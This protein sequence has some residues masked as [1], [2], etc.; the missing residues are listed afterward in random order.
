MSQK[1]QELA[2]VKSEIARENHLKLHSGEAGSHDSHV[3]EETESHDNL[4]SLLHAN[5]ES[6]EEER[7]KERETERKRE[8]KDDGKNEHVQVPE[9]HASKQA[10]PS[11][12]PSKSYPQTKVAEVS[13]P[14]SVPGT[15]TVRTPSSV[16]KRMF[17]ART[18]QLLEAEGEVFRRQLKM[19]RQRKGEGSGREK[20]K[21]NSM[22]EVCVREAGPASGLVRKLDFSGEKLPSPTKQPARAAEKPDLPFPPELVKEGEKLLTVPQ[23]D[24][25]W[26]KGQNSPD[27]SYREKLERVLGGGGEEEVGKVGGGERGVVTRRSGEAVSEPRRGSLQ[28]VH[29]AV[30]SEGR[31]MRRWSSTGASDDFFSDVMATIE[32]RHSMGSASGR[33]QAT[34]PMQQRGRRRVQFSPEA[35]ILQAALDGELGTVRECVKKVRGP[36]PGRKMMARKLTLCSPSLSWVAAVRSAI[37]E[38]PACTTQCALATSPLYSSWWR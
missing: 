23:P 16:R 35:I 33:G 2:R 1:Q 5:E 27:I 38:P 30:E 13:G 37:K 10:P 6:E 12:P 4:E 14:G 29:H 21:K 15:P 20:E 26:Y 9:L 32:R 11:P 17:E 18:R 31:G 22:E 3:I 7:E 28:E 34:R 24:E 25:E 8:R 36:E 19:E